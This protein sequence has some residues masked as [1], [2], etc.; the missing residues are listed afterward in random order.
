MS[1]ESDTVAYPDTDERTA[2]SAMRIYAWPG[3]A[4]SGARRRIFWRK[5]RIIDEVCELS[6]SEALTQLP[7]DPTGEKLQHLSMIIDHYLSALS[8]APSPSSVGFRWR[9]KSFPNI[10]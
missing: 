8:V 9:C 2:W 4:G 7:S 10:C 6:S 5:S 1:S 3:L